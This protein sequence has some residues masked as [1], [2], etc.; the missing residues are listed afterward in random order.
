MDDYNKFTYPGFDVFN[1]RAG[2]KIK[3]VEVWVNAL[4]AGNKYYAII[5][6]KNATATGSS[7]YSYTLGDPREI[8]VGLA[9]HF[10]KN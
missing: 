3:Q 10:G 4:N 9:Y 5:S 8:T 7:S 6:S 1:I 2:Y